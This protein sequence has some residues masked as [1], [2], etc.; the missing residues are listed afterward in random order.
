MKL[1][2]VVIAIVLCFF[3]W[4]AISKGDSY[5]TVIDGFNM[6]LWIAIPIAAI[7]AIAAI[8]DIFRK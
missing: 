2:N 4:E 1:I 6:P 8:V 5:V 7:C 3:V